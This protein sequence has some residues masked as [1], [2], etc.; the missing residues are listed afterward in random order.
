ME[1]SHTTN[2]TNSKAELAAEALSPN[3]DGRECYNGDLLTIG[4]KD[5]N[6]YPKG[7]TL[8]FIVLAL[9]LSVF[10]SALDIVSDVSFRR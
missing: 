2:S 1:M 4:E 7:A 5:A 9:V 3:Q 8:T 10:L 6:N